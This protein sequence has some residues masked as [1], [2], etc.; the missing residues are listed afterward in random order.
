M[1]AVPVDANVTTYAQER[2]HPY[3]STA[4]RLVLSIVEG[5]VDARTDS[6]VLVQTPSAA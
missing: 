1:M 4:R 2:E 5:D 3:R 6:E